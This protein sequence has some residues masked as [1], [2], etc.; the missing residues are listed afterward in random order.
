MIPR[1]IHQIFINFKGK[2]LKQIPEYSESHKKTIKYCEKNNIELKLWDE[3]ELLELLSQYPEFSHLWE[4]FRYPIQKVDFMRYVILYHY[5]G[6]YI[7][8]DIYPL[9]DMN[10]LFEM[11][12]FFTRWND[13]QD[14]YNAILGTEPKTDMYY[15]ILHHSYESFYEKAEMDIYNSWKARFV[16]QTTGHQMLNRVFK[17]LKIPEDKKLNIVSVYN[18]M[19]RICVVPPNDQGI[20]MDQSASLW[21]DGKK[22]Y[23]KGCK[24]K[25]KNRRSEL[26]NKISGSD[27]NENT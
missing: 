22:I 24:E 18:Q 1:I 15:G 12:Y 13:S 10:H 9:R 6:I 19:K 20:F 8:L 23:F 14:V 17:R 2:E 3:K 21:Y 25:Y 5:G 16:Y 26:K 27:I 4:D 7:D 11:D